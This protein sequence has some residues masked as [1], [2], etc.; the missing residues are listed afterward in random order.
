MATTY[1]QAGGLYSVNTLSDRLVTIDST[2]GQVS[3]VGPIGYDM[4]AIHTRLATIGTRLF[5]FTANADGNDIYN[6]PATYTLLELNPATG[7]K[8]SQHDINLASGS[9]PRLIE[10]FGATNGKLYIGLSST[11]VVSTELGELDPATGQVSNVIDYG[12]IPGAGLYFGSFGVDLDGL[13][14]EYGTTNLF[15]Y[16]GDGTFRSFARIDPDNVTVSGIAQFNWNDGIT[17][18]A[19]AEFGDFWMGNTSLYRLHANPQSIDSIPLS[20]AG[21]FYGLAAVPEPS[22]FL[23]AASG[24]AML[25]MS[26]RKRGRGPQARRGVLG[27]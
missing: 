1:A 20:V 6:A 4:R 7:A 13:E 5:A 16:D 8:I 25:G 24:A 3:V 11:S 2:T 23:L 21:S 15:A 19:S 10:G 14:G 26:L 12:Q 9:A 18:L 22:T 17:D 27:R